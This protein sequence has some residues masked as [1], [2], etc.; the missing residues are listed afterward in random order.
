MTK[1]R[2][3]IKTVLMMVTLV[4]MVMSVLVIDE[5]IGSYRSGSGYR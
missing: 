4:V 5:G 3:V 2:C 1:V